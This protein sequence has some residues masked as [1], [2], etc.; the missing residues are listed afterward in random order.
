MKNNKHLFILATWWIIMVI[1][2][3]LWINIGLALWLFFL[4]PSMIFGA[5]YD[6]AWRKR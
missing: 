4:L 6:N 2:V 5:F 3:A 1:A